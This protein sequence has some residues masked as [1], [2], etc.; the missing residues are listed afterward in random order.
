MIKID[1]NFEVTVIENCAGS[2]SIIEP[3]R[4]FDSTDPIVKVVC[5]QASEHVDNMP[6]ILVQ[7]QNNKL[8]CFKVSFEKGENGKDFCRV[9]QKSELALGAGEGVAAVSNGIVCLRSGVAVRTVS[10]DSFLHDRLTKQNKGNELVAET[11]PIGL[12]NEEQVL[13]LQITPKKV[14]IADIDAYENLMSGAIVPASSNA[15]FKSGAVGEPYQ[16]LYAKHTWLA[17]STEAQSE[18]GPIEVKFDR[19]ISLV[20]LNIDVSFETH[21]S[22]EFFK[23]VSSDNQVK[24]EK[25]ETSQIVTTIDQGKKEGVVN[26]AKMQA[27][28]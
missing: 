4:E 10:I 14:T 5:A 20:S 18:I 7:T 11:K 16:N 6:R 13:N 23:K 15:S 8:V 19:P 21:N 22:E 2:Q 12:I 3:L 1:F 25:K 27:A 9:I 17:E 28:S 24:E 26:E